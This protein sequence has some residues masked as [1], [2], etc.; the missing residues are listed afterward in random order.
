MVEVT[1]IDSK[2]HNDDTASTPPP[3]QVK[4]STKTVRYFSPKFLQD[5]E[6]K[7]KEAW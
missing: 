6:K 1:V 7:K 3:M 5:Q 2:N 4:R